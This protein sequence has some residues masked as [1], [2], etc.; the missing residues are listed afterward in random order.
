MFNGKSK[1]LANFLFTLMAYLDVKD[2]T[3]DDKK[4][5]FA[6][7]CLEGDALMWWRSI[8]AA[9]TFTQQAANLKTGVKLCQTSF[10][11]WIMNSSST[12]VCMSLNRPKV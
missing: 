3:S 9:G 2:V 8:D 1:D 12:A 4:I 6:A 5:A 10:A 11:Q 7:T